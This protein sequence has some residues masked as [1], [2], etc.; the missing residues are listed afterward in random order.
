MKWEKKKR[1]KDESEDYLRNIYELC[2]LFHYYVI[3]PYI[4]KRMRKI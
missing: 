4:D 2:L 1:Q 3:L